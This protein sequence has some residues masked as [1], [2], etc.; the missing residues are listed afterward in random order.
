[1]KKLLALVMTLG[2]VLCTAACGGETP[3]ADKNDAVGETITNTADTVATAKAYDGY[4]FVDGGI[5]IGI[6]MEYES[7]GLP[8]AK[9][10]FEAPSCAGQGI[11]YIY[12]YG[13]YEIET[14][15]LDDKNLIGYITI[16]DD[17]VATPEGIDVSMTKDDVIRV[18]GA[19]EEDGSMI[20]YKKGT[21]KLNFIFDEA[22]NIVSIEYVSSVLG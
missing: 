18:Y 20:T 9:S 5:S 7:L 16:K 14:Y 22:G 8:A 10:V 12:N 3:S 11:S 2:M 6:D 17:M 13:S 4:A 1:M 21:M 15:P 19:G